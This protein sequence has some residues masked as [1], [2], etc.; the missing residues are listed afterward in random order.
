MRHLLER[1]QR[2]S[3]EPRS[4]WNGRKEGRTA[5][6]RVNVVGKVLQR[7]R[8]QGRKRRIVLCEFQTI[9]VRVCIVFDFTVRDLRDVVQSVPTSERLARDR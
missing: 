8:V 5:N 9:I 7:M 4:A 6:V 2:Y 1:L 3:H